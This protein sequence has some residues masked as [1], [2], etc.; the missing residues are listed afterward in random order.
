MTFR[1]PNGDTEAN[2]SLCRLQCEYGIV[3]YNN[4]KSA[5]L[6]SRD[7]DLLTGSVGVIDVKWLPI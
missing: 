2:I 3:I 5:Y 6:V 7:E 1:L 4:E